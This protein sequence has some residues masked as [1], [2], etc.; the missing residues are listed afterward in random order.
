MIECR[1]CKGSNFI[2][3]FC[4]AT[5]RFVY[6]DCWDCLSEEMYA[7]EMQEKITKILISEPSEELLTT[8]SGILT[9][10][11]IEDKEGALMH[12]DIEIIWNLMRN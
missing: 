2:K 5:E 4:H 7:L 9:R 10:A 8:V 6:D 3:T 12:K 11:V 1:E